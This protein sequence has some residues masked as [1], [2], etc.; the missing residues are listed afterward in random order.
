M[1]M[2][3]L[4]PVRASEWLL[5]LNEAPQDAALHAR[6]QT[7]LAASPDHARDWEEM[8][9]TYRLMG[10]TVPA[11]RQQWAAAPAAWRPG[12]RV[13]TAAAIVAAACLALVFAPEALLRLQADTLTATAETR[14]LRL[15]DGSS[16]HLAPRSA[17]DV[18]FSGNERRVRLLAGEAFFEVTPDASR[19]FVVS[20]GMVETTV[21]GTAFD[22]RRGDGQTWVG[23]RRG[24]VR[25]EDGGAAPPVSVDLL[26]GDWV[27]LDRGGEAARGHLP[28]DRMAAWTRGDLIV[29]DAPVADVIAAIR[30]YYRGVIVLNGEKLARQPLT[31]IYRLSDPVEAVRA[32][33][34]TQGAEMRRFSPWLLVVSGE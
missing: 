5:A 34:E 22:V 18:A 16:I 21:L 27:G 26:A 23:V 10:M 31:G 14:V 9:R 32:I 3:Y 24:H 12:R 7:W 1:T 13:V 17:V 25:V 11:F 30:P 33:A 15:E 19:P 8:E 29:R 2:A 20:A 28:A 6:F 4:E